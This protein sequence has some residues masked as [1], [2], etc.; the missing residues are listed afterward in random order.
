MKAYIVNCSTGCTCCSYQNHS[1]GPYLTREH[2]EDACRRFLETKRLASQYA[3]RGV[4]EIEECEAEQLP[5]GR[6]I[7]GNIVLP[8][9]AK[10][11]DQIDFG[12]GNE[13]RVEPA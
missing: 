7:I 5:D 10:F 11:D 3:R 6:L 2:A 9:F 8:G 12:L 13:H 4:Y 1:C